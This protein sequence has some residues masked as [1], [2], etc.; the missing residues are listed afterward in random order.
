MEPTNI[1]RDD[2]PRRKLNAG[3]KERKTPTE[4]LERD[5]R[6]S[7]EFQRSKEYTDNGSGEKIREK[8][9]T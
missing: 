5:Q 1:K 4:P 6:K 2:S 7:D 8:I 3:V 9:P